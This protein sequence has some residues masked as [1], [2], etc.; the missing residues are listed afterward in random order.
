ML[1][2]FAFLIWTKWPSFNISVYFR[3]LVLVNSVKNKEFGQLH[4][5]QT[6]EQLTPREK[7]YIKSLGK[8]PM[9]VYQITE[10]EVEKIA[11]YVSEVNRS[12]VGSAHG[13]D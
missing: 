5:S 3:G 7:R 13:A 1:D 2:K 9:S 12:T 11:T 8:D 10:E 6:F 4:L